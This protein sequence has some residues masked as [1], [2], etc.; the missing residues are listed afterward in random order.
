MTTMAN[1]F[2]DKYNS[3]TVPDI[4]NRL[5]ALDNIRVNLFFQILTGLL[6]NRKLV[7]E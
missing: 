5:V 3:Q 4:F 1:L 6:T 2:P 7:V